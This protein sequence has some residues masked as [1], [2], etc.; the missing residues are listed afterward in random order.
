[1]SAPIPKLEEHGLTVTQDRVI[2]PENEPIFDAANILRLDHD[3][4]Y[5][6]SSSGN[7]CGAAWLQQTL[8]S[9]YKVHVLDNLYASTHIDTTI[10]VIRPGLVLL[11]GDRVNQTNCPAIFDGWDKIFVKD[12][13]PG[14]FY[15]YPYG[16]KWMALNMLSVSSDVVICDAIQVDLIKE[17]ERRKITVVPL[18][19]RHARTLGG[20]F[21]CVTL[22]LERHAL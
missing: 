22:D 10:T 17:L 16:S 4:L 2:L 6:V 1:V 15:H 12:V 21:H 5:L 9:T 3:I 20:G 11:N 18:T 8:G 7:R 19:L 14:S 13:V